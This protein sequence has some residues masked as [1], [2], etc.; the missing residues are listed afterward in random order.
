MKDAAT[1]FARVRR[2]SRE[3]GDH[4]D[5][6]ENFHAPPT[7]LNHVVSPARSFGSATLSLADVKQ[8]AKQLGVSINDIVLATAAG[9]L[10]ELLLHYDEQA[11][12]PIIASVP[13]ATDKSANRIT[14]NE[15]SGLS[16][17]LPVHVADPLERVRLVSLA[18]GIA[19]E[20]HEILGPGV[21]RQAHDLSPDGGRARRVPLAVQA[22]QSEQDHER[23][24]LERRGP[25]AARSLR[26]RSRV[27]DL[28]D[29]RAVAWGA[30]QHHGVELCRP[31]GH[32]GAHRRP[33]LRRRARGDGGPGP[34]VRRNPKRRRH[35][36]RPI[37][38]R[39][40]ALPAVGTAR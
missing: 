28:F 30:G 21:V 37:R 27:R 18:T 1:G 12:Q 16:V 3:R 38:G 39:S 14:G 8:T 31:D 2:R 7:F 10:R 34:R 6:A 19:K 40:T 35:S 22:G 5:L 13:T 17:S 9:G 24:G 36:G 32:R 26:R 11:D 15:I 29:G 20:D 33:H 4:P 23:R 25:A